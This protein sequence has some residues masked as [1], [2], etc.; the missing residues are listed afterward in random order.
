MKFEYLAQ[1]ELNTIDEYS[2]REKETFKDP[3]EITIKITVERTRYKSVK[4]RRK[5]PIFE[6]IKDLFKPCK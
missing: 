2:F 1:D 4:N 3:I 6:I 5:T